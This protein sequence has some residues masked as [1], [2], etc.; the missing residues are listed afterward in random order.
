MAYIYYIILPFL[1]GCKK[2]SLPSDSDRNF[3]PG[4]GRI[5]L[6]KRERRGTNDGFNSVLCPPGAADL[7]AAGGECPVDGAPAGSGISCRRLFAQRLSVA[8]ISYIETPLCE[9]M[10]EFFYPRP[11]MDMSERRA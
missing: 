8:G 1:P 4:H 11:T 6:E 7:P 3:T 2:L 9:S 5:S 10:T